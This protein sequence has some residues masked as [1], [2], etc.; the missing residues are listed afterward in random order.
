VGRWRTRKY[1]ICLPP[2]SRCDSRCLFGSSF[3]FY[4]HG[5]AC[6][7][8]PA[9][10]ISPAPVTEPATAFVSSMLVAWIALSTHRFCACLLMQID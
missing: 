1:Q 8:A 6:V 5:M 10:W 3:T 2:S 7:A 9:G 4:T